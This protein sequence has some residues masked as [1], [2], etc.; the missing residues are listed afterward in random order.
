MTRLTA[1]V[2]VAV[3]CGLAGPPPQNA[4]EAPSRKVRIDIVAVDRKGEPVHDLKADEIEVWIGHYR[5]PIETLTIVS[6]TPGVRASRSIVLLL[7]DVTISPAVVPRA[8]AAALRLVSRIGPGDQ[9]TV[10][11]LSGTSM[12]T[13][14]DPARLRRM[15]DA[16]NVRATG[17]TRIDVLSEHVLQTI[18]G[19]AR[20]MVEA[21]GVRKTIVAIGSGAVFDRPLPP[22]GVGRDVEPD[23]IE[24]MR[25]LAFAHMHLYVIDPVGVGAT[26]ADGGENGFARASG[27]HAFLNT[28]DTTAAVDRILRDASNYY[29]V[30]VSDPPVGRKSDL[31]ELEIRVLRSGVTVLA[32]RAIPGGK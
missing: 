1:L 26:P 18:A 21:P 23:W 10:L 30:T 27:G 9:M 7:D 29:V 20:Q 12:E 4:A 6:P 15:L 14:G 31:R 3:S 24:A 19:L 25:A 2:L 5:V 16:F 8:R 13:T 11:T 28:N 32:P 22:P 17:L